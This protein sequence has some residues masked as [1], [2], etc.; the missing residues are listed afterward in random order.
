MTISLAS[1]IRIPWWLPVAGLALGTL[2]IWPTLLSYRL[3]HH[4]FPMLDDTSNWLTTVR[5]AVLSIGLR[6]EVRAK[7]R[8]VFYRFYPGCADKIRRCGCSPAV[9]SASVLHGK[10]TCAILKVILA[11]RLLGV[12]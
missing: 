12:Y 5:K 2:S 9:L 7:A 8:C 10:R 3:L 11:P 6:E 4:A 1:R